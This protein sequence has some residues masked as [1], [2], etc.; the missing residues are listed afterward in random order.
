MEKLNSES[1]KSR[2]LFLENTTVNLFKKTTKGRICNFIIIILGAVS[3]FLYKSLDI[4]LILS[5]L[6]GFI[7]YL[8]LGISFDIFIGKF[9]RIDKQVD[10]LLNH[11]DGQKF[12]QE[13]GGDSEQIEGIKKEVEIFK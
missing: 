6:F 10:W 4:S 7:T 1:A 5:L 11:P 2:N 9:F 12:L 8:I 13:K 3:I